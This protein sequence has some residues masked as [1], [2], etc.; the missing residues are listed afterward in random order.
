MH[1]GSDRSIN[2]FARSFGTVT[3]MRSVIDEKVNI[4][5]ATVQFMVVYSLNG[6]IWLYL[7][8]PPNVTTLSIS[9]E[10]THTGVYVPFWSKRNNTIE[11]LFADFLF[12]GAILNTW[13]IC[14]LFAAI[15]GYFQS[16]IAFAYDFL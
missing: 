12:C 13:S 1:A 10:I 9:I 6:Y 2:A 16:L 4:A 8:T 3:V 15:L 7:A 5:A 14:R 11:L